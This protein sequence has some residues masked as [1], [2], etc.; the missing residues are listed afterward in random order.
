MPEHQVEWELDML[1][2]F[3]RSLPYPPTPDIAARVTARLDTPAGTQRPAWRT[4]AAAAVVA[5]VVFAAAMAVSRDVR[6]AVADFLGLAVEGERIE[7]LPTPAGGVGATPLPTP[8]ELEQIAR[9]VTFAEAERLARFPLAT[10]PDRQPESIYLLEPAGAP[11]V[12][13]L[14]Y[15]DFDLWQFQTNGSPGL[16]KGIVD[17]T[18]VRETTVSGHRAYWIQ[19]AERLVW[20]VNDEG[21]PIAGTQRTVLAPTLLWHDGLRYLRIEGISDEAAAVAIAEQMR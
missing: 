17:G 3:A 16:G 14:R 4:L 2:E 12:V 5:M 20:F 8:V 10:Q 1:Q 6:D 21:T 7:R 13:I 19:G 11:V 15:A 9:E 18:V